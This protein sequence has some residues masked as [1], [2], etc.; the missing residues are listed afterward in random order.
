MKKHQSEG[1][2]VLPDIYDDI[3]VNPDS[4]KCALMFKRFEELI[5]R[6]PAAYEDIMA[7]YREALIDLCLCKDIDPKAPTANQCK[8]LTLM[9]DY[10]MLQVT[11][12]LGELAPIECLPQQSAYLFAS[13]DPIE[14]LS[15]SPPTPAWSP[16]ASPIRRTYPA[17]PVPT[18]RKRQRTADDKSIEHIIDS[19]EISDLENESPPRVKRQRPTPK[20][21]LVA[22]LLRG[23][24]D[25][26]EEQEDTGP[27]SLL[28]SPSEE[29]E[30]RQLLRA[31]GIAA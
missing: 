2:R 26:K 12:R 27:H 4:A 25:E 28:C 3:P 31:R 17:T 18:S 23:H 30:I 8:L 19:I 1:M 13:P 7:E 9:E 21:S 6:P 16:R 10:G 11:K 24:E 22:D 29:E 20:T 15:C 14:E 5:A